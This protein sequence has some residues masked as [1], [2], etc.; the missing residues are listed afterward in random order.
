M[1]CVK[2]CLDGAL[3]V[4]LITCSQNFFRTLMSRSYVQGNMI[5]ELFLLSF[6]LGLRNQIFR[7]QTL[8]KNCFVS[9]VVS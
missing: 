6:L 8:I 2:T 1:G 5:F 4:Q 9:M 7:F 3:K